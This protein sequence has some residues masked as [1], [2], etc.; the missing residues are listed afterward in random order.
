[1]S[2]IVRWLPAL[3]AS[4]LTTVLLAALALLIATLAGIVAGLL[5]LHGPRPLRA[6]IRLYVDLI[7]GVPILVLLY[8]WY[9][10]SSVVGSGLDP[11]AAAVAAL[12]VFAAAHVTEIVRGGIGS[13]SPHT[14]EAAQS[15]GLT[16]AQRFRLVTVPLVLPRVVPPWVNTAIEV[17]KATSL[18][19]LIG[20]Q[21]LIFRM[22][23]AIG[24]NPLGDT[25]P[26]YL[27]A[28]AMYLMIG[29]GL[30]WIGARIERRYRYLEY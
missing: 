23:S 4:L 9:F 18:A 20:V 2:P 22:Q 13:L 27:F 11:L 6:L 19:S 25:M 26:F 5:L 10:V 30:S 12:S 17:V 15:T 8:A 1:M 3:T 29:L 7:R 21:D 16:A 14:A 28:A 24:S